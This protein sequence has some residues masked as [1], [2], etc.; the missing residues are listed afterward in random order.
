M[1][2]EKKGD[3]S[4]QAIAGTHIVL[5][6][7]I[8]RAASLPDAGAKLTPRVYLHIAKEEQRPAGSCRDLVFQQVNAYHLTSTPMASFPKWPRQTI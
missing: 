7:S 3:L 2:N 6:A 1:R 8:C 4:V 5:L